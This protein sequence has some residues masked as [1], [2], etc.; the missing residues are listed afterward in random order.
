MGALQKTQ[1]L[2][3]KPVETLEEWRLATGM[4]AK[5]DR[6]SVVSP[7]AICAPVNSGNFEYDREHTRLALWN[8]EIAGVLRIHTEIICIGEARLRMGGLGS[9]KVSRA[10][11]RK[12]VLHALVRD[13]MDYLSHHGHHVSMI[14]GNADFFCR[15]GFTAALPDY[16]IV[17]G[18]SGAPA[19][20]PT[21]FRVRAIKP[22]DIA[23]VQ[24]IHIASEIDVPC[25]LLRAQR[26]YANRWDRFKDAEVLTSRHGK[27]VGYLLAHEEGNS[28][29]VS[30]V[31]VSSNGVCR[32]VLLR[33]F[34]I[35]HDKCLAR[36]HFLCAP[37]SVFTHYLRAY[38]S[39]HETHI[40]PR[41]GGMIAVVDMDETLESMIPEWE[42]RL[43]SSALNT[44]RCEVVL[45]I[46]SVPYRIRA[47]RGALDVAQASG[48]NKFSISSSDLTR[49]LV[50]AHHLDDVFY[51][52][53]RLITRQG[54]EL[55]EVLFPKRDPYFSVPDRF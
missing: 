18:V 24:K 32:D 46:G 14:F 53:R 50:G 39:V 6:A 8:T 31:G 42:S 28:L 12:G 1:N 16:V 29:S 33:C 9:I 10:H 47:N 52:E 38:E 13:S 37:D 55:L 2:V 26:H 20:R 25:S 17:L 40:F 30:E 5:T 19:T 54:K 22:G 48:K 21:E 49:L 41:D 36:I 27:V 4:M 23:A 35:A 44:A 15:Y 51:R 7:T 3:V 11:H 34:R 43:A 45:R